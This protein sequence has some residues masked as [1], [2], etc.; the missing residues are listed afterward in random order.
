MHLRDGRTTQAANGVPSGKAI[1][2]NIDTNTLPYT[3]CKTRIIDLSPLKLP[4]DPKTPDSTLCQ[5]YRDY[6]NKY[7]SHS[8]SG[9]RNP[10]QTKRASAKERA[11]ASLEATKIEHA[12]S[13]ATAILS[14]KTGIAPPVAFPTETVYGLGA[15]A[16]NP[17]SIAGIFAAKGRPS[18]NPLI[19]HVSSINHLERC[20][21]GT[22]KESAIPEI[23][24]D[25]V[26]EFW[27]GPLTILVPVPEDG[28]GVK[29]APN[30]HPGQKT[31]GFRV[32]SSPHARFLMAVTDRP[33]AAPSANSSGKPSPTTAKHVKDDLNGKINFILNGGSCDVGVE[34]TVVDGLGETP[35]ILRPGGLSK[36]ALQKWGKKHGNVWQHV[37]N[38]WEV[39]KTGVKRKRSDLNETNGD[40]ASSSTK[41]NSKTNDMTNG[42]VNGTIDQEDTDH[43]AHE[44]SES[45]AAPRAPGMK[46]KHYAP[47]GRL[48]LFESSTSSDSKPDLRPL[49]TKLKELLDARDITANDTTV[50]IVKGPEIPGQKQELGRTRVPAHSL[51]I[52]VLTS[53]SWPGYGDIDKAL[54]NELH[55]DWTG[56]GSSYTDAHGVYDL[57]VTK[58]ISIRSENESL[59]KELKIEQIELGRDSATISRNLFAALRTCDDSGCDWIFAEAPSRAAIKISSADKGSNEDE[60][61][62]D[63]ET[64]LERL[65]KAATEIIV[66]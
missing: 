23:Y 42:N 48:F 11:T 59:E 56:L 10:P 28:K 34:S 36:T 37:E 52:G 43:E 35:L 5:I 2:T 54:K 33:I 9:G 40:S 32:P 61:I 39:K 30:V 14:L 31:I 3:N 20:L 18:D 41:K 50:D 55:P 47:K 49:H 29:F 26:N 17:A 16:T 13:L 57:N 15:D 21:G 66:T 51:T 62:E 53:T 7:G 8:S 22:T 12:E 4:K 60:E 19:V 27:P 25:L 38:G 65:R 6:I 24:R 64:V 58:A 46:Y 45:T 63:F 44:D 1:D